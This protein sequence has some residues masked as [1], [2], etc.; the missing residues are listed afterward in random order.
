[1]SLLPQDFTCALNRTAVFRAGRGVGGAMEPH[2]IA[3]FGPPGAAQDWPKNR[4]AGSGNPVQDQRAGAQQI[5]T[6]THR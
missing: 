6:K 1:M 2:L 5:I 4:T 3:V